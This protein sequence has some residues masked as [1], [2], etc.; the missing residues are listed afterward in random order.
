MTTVKYLIDYLKDKPA[1]MPVGIHMFSEMNS[2]CLEEIEEIETCLPRPDG[3]IPNSRPDKPRVK[4]L[5][6]PGN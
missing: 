6:F 3:W 4:C 5:I 1:N 2:L